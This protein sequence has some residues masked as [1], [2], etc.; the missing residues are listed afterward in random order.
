VCGFGNVVFFFLQATVAAPDLLLPLLTP[1]QPGADPAPFFFFF[2]FR[3]LVYVFT[4]SALRMQHAQKM[5][6]HESKHPC[7]QRVAGRKV[8]HQRK[9]KKEGK[10][11]IKRPPF[12]FTLFHAAT[13]AL[14]GAIEAMR[15]VCPSSV[16]Y[17]MP[18]D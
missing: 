11:T 18:L 16:S 7:E 5:K 4:H 8:L 2:F 3:W 14:A 6:Q 15:R 12:I 10:N 13:A 1:T 17:S 9:K